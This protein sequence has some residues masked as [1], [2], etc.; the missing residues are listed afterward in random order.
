MGRYGRHKTGNHRPRINKTKNYSYLNEEQVAA[1]RGDE[2]LPGEGK[3]HCNI[4]W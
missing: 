4:C 3:F 2:D 1:D